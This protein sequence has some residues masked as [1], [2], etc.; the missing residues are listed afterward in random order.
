MFDVNVCL[1]IDF[2]VFY[3]DVLGCNFTNL[4]TGKRHY[5]CLSYT[6]CVLWDCKASNIQ[7]VILSVDPLQPN[8]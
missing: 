7:S 6:K 1:S 3:Y 5:S 4:A 8:S 2:S